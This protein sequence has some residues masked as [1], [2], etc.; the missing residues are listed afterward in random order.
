MKGG[1]DGI[2]I[3][4]VKVLTDD[5]WRDKEPTPT[6]K[7]IATLTPNSLNVTPPITKGVLPL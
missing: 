5:S 2:I 3:S 4:N 7:A 1:Y 6:K